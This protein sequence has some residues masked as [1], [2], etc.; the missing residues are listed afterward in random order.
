MA[1]WPSFLSGLVLPTAD[2]AEVT[3]SYNGKTRV[4]GV[5]IRRHGKM[6]VT[7]GGVPEGAREQR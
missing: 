6:L 3:D 4:V 2:R 1:V 7:I 5:P